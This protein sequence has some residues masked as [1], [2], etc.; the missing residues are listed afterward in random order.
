ML[1]L[2]FLCDGLEA[3]T[4]PG[5]AEIVLGGEKWAEWGDLE[6]EWPGGSR[7]LTHTAPHLLDREETD[8]AQETGEGVHKS[9]E[10]M[11]FSWPGLLQVSS[12]LLVERE[13]VACAQAGP[14]GFFVFVCK[15]GIK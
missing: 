9:Q 4:Q 3:G 8:W 13:N 15:K 2:Y 10:V 6:E 5:T 1:H 11:H 12:Q 14:H 7:E